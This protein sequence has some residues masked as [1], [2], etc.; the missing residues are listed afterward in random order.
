M[1]PQTQAIISAVVKALDAK[2]SSRP[3]YIRQP[4]LTVADN[5]IQ[6]LK[7]ESN[8]SSNHV[9]RCAYGHIRP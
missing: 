2:A 7:E 6:Q 1:T 3:Y 5:L 8:G 9:R 4:M